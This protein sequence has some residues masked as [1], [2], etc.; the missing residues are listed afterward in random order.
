[1]SFTAISK[2]DTT[3]VFAL[4]NKAYSMLETHTDSAYILANNAQRKTAAFKQDNAYNKTAL[5]LGIYHQTQ[6]NF[7][8]A[9]QYFATIL[10]NA[11]SVDVILLVRANLQLGVIKR[12]QGDLNASTDCFS[13]AYEGSLL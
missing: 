10:N 3:G 12:L 9:A 7:D 1:M 2:H 13:K 5:V 11:Q 8:S 4:A 6:S